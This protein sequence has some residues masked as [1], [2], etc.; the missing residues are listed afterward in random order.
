MRYFTSVAAALVLACWPLAPAAAQ[1]EAGAPPT[2]PPAGASASGGG[3]GGGGVLRL[4]PE[5]V[6]TEHEGR[7]GGEAV[8]YR[9]TAG[10]LPL[11]GGDGE[12]T[13]EVFHVA[14]LRE[15]A[16]P[17]R[18]VTFVFNGGPGAASAFLN[19]GAI[20]PRG[21]AFSATGGYLPP[22]ARLVDNPDSWLA[23]TDLVFVDPVGTGY[24][25]PAV[26]GDEAAARFY[27]VRRDASAMAAFIRLWL[28]G[29]GRT[30]APLFLAGESYGGFR[31]ALLAQA[32]PEES[33][34][35]PSGLVLIS[36]ALEFSLLRGTDD[37]LLAPWAVSLPSFAAVHLERQGGV[38]AA[39]ELARRLE[40]VERFALADYLVALAAGARGL[41]PALEAELARLTG[42]P[43]E[44]VRDERGRIPPTRFAR[45]YARAQGRVLSLYDGS[46]DGP[47]AAP[48]SGHRG[49]G[50]DPVLDP[51]VPVWTSAIVGHV[52]EELGYRTDVT[53]RLLEGEVGGRWDYGTTATRQG[54][55]GALD[56]LQAGRALNPALEVLV[57]HGYTD[58]V[59]PYLGSRYLLDQLP[60]LA[61]A[62]PV[63]FRAYPGGHMFYMR[64]ESRRR[65]TEDARAAYARAAA[66]AS[67]E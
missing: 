38:A 19:L 54:Y 9:A 60:P 40:P 2:R 29:A 56:A 48:G 4:L 3:G 8:R 45:E 1:G 37:H 66:A 6:T 27:G 10:T 34:L 17:G 42:L 50:V 12:V 13:A 52:R 15:P 30:L 39:D 63:A 47:D 65:L 61:G 35:A 14:Y 28:A 53:Y 55:A 67:R 16:E 7:V 5:P 26:S 58:L 23:F 41:T 59:T 21:V 49:G 32:L 44:I 31:A 11:R 33:G 22:P 20:G 24:S 64:P 36:P 62:V 25:R 46:V 57:V 43:A 51:A 18:P